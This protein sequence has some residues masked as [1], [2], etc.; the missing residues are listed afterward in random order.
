LRRLADPSA[1]LTLDAETWRAVEA[2][3]AAVARIADRD[4]P[5]YGI[6]TGFGKLASRRIAA[7]DLRELQRRIVL[8]HAAG[9]GAA[10]PDRVVRLA[11]VLK[12]IA[13]A[14][15]AS[16]V[17]RRTVEALMRLVAADVLPVIP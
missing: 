16:G 11:M 15:G 12:V 6:N 8:S 1:P 10:L 13:L 4:A 2:A 9:V 14:R 5:A 7:G 3:A 17:T